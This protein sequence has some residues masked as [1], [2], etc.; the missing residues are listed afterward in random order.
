MSE[1]IR[2]TLPAP[3]EGLTFAKILRFIS[4]PFRP[5]LSE[6]YLAVP[7]F[8]DVPID[9]LKADGIRGVLLDAD[10]TLCPHHAREFS[11]EVVRHIGQMIESGLKV[12]I[13][14]NA[15]EDRFRQVPKVAVVT[16]VPPKPD[17]RGF[18]KAMKE[19]LRLDD[20][21]RV[22]MIGDNFITD[23]GAGAA[24]MRFIHVAPV[25][26]NESLLHGLTRRLALACARIHSPAAFQKPR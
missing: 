16:G 20:P 12:A 26:G 19:F 1:T 11:H 10:G 9:R 15:C 7:R 21:S 6:T 18:E 22:C 2:E 8:I 13:Y 23:G 17:R 5:R 14:T 24:G 3:R 25:A 4:L